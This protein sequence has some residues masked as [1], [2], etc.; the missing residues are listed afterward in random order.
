MDNLRHKQ[1]VESVGFT[2]IELM[3][4]TVI[5]VTGLVTIL[6]SILAMNSQQRY[7]DQD[8][9][10]SNYMAYLLEDLQQNVTV[11]GDISNVTGYTSPFGLLFVDEDNEVRDFIPGLGHVKLRMVQ[12]ADG[13]TDKTVEIQ[14]IITVQ[15]PRGRWIPYTTSK[16]I[17]Y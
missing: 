11:N 2:L 3:I 1:L 5:L 13:A 9:I 10:T 8:A 15:D 4:A 16:L 14:I 7:A 12:G 6:G 17:T